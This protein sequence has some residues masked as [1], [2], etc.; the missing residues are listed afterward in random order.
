MDATE[1]PSPSR[2]DPTPDGAAASG[3]VPAAATPDQAS[4]ATAA[5]A[6][7]VPAGG[8]AA[9]TPGG[10]AAHGI[11]SHGGHAGAEAGG[12]VV[13]VHRPGYP[14]R[15][16]EPVPGVGVERSTLPDGVLAKEAADH[17][18]VWALL[19]SGASEETR[20]LGRLRELVD[21]AGARIW[22][23][24][25]DA[26]HALVA[27]V[28]DALRIHPLV[29]EDIAERGQRPKL[30]ITGDEAHIVVYAIA[31]GDRLETTEIDMVLARDYLLTSHP[32]AW[33]PLETHHL[34]TGPA[35]LLARGSDY[36]AWALIDSLVDSYYPIVDGIDSEIDTLE[37][38]ILQSADRSS[39]ERLLDVKRSIVDLRR[40]VSPTRE[41]FNQL[42]N[43]ELGLV[44]PETILYFRDVYD[45]LVRLNEELDS[46]REVASG[47]LDVYL[48]SV[49]NNL[50]NIMKRLTGVTVI[51]AGVA[52][53]GGIFGMSEA[54]AALE[55]GE[56]TGFWVVTLV[57]VLGAGAVA[58]L[59]RRFDWI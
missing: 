34:R 40:V 54:G 25:V 44:Q 33:D 39:L 19:S 35:P 51:L 26:T 14:A 32:A 9:G 36:L 18:R 57:I 59:L 43:R 45:H 37:D 8:T 31:Y 20:D 11:G 6:T 10:L 21:D 24:L 5:S 3:S 56:H 17:L 4:G 1:K 15:R 27:E 48:T 22:V 46:V 16:L 23:D 58:L 28:A 55:G 12:D 49:N 2:S 41:V 47:I 52:A 13:V 50:S 30:E 42:T 38:D 53:V 7:P 29:A